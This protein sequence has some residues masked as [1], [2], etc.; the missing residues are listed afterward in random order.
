MG[1]WVVF[2][3][4]KAVVVVVGIGERD[5]PHCG[6]A[7]FGFAETLLF[8][9]G[10]FSFEQDRRSANERCASGDSPTFGKPRFRQQAK[11]FE[12]PA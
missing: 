6:H 3:R 1:G 2:G 4:T 10:I 9:L 8:F 12:S 11:P 5:R 7:R